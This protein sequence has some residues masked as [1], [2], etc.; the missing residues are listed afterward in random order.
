MTPP[1]SGVPPEE[2][3]HDAFLLR[4][5]PDGG[6]R[7][8][9]GLPARRGR[10]LLGALGAAGRAVRGQPPVLARP[11]TAIRKARSAGVAGSV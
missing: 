4:G 7:P 3:A 6:T 11:A 2:D 8:A 9:L 1:S 5:P 10:G